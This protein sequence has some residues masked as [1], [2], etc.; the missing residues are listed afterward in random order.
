MIHRS[1]A[2]SHL[3]PDR[4]RRGVT[5][6]ELVISMVVV[7]IALSGS[8]LALHQTIVSSADPMIQQQASAIAE[9]L[10]EEVLAKA[11]LD[12]DSGDVCP[13]PEVQRS[14]YD[15]V[16]DYQGFDES[17]VSTQ[18]G[19]AVAGLELYRARIAVDTTASLSGL[20]GAAQLL[21]IDVRVNFSSR[22][23][24]TLSGYRTK[25]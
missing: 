6:I 18:E 20:S 1:D 15:N 14:L 13:T 25:L 3:D 23:D 10:L 11:Y 17:G 19:V 24:L 12:P 7:G 16:C 5:L 8:F 9:A 4:R 2:A 21:R 22:V